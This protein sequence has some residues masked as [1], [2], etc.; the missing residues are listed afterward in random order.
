MNQPRILVVEDENIVALDIKMRLERFG[1]QVIAT[2]PSG[3]E[4]IEQALAAKPDLI[5][6]DIKLRGK[7][8]GIDAA[9]QIQAWSNIPIIFLTAFADE[10]T[11]QRAINAEPFGYILKPFDERELNLVIQVTLFRYQ[12]EE[13]LRLSEAAEREQRALAEALSDIAKTLNSTL[14]LQKIIY[15]ILNSANRVVASNRISLMLMFAPQTVYVAGSNNAEYGLFIAD[16][17]NHIY[18]YTQMPILAHM[19]KSRQPLVI[20]DTR[21]YDDWPAIPETAH[22]LA[23]MGAPIFAKD[24]LLGFINLSSRQAHAFAD[25]PLN[26]LQAFAD[27]AAIAL[28]NASL[29]QAT[30]T[31]AGLLEQR[32]AQ[33]TEEL[34][35]ERTRLQLILD[36]VGDPIYFTDPQFRIQYANAQ[37]EKTTGYSF[38][39]IL[40][41]TPA[42]WRGTTSAAVILEM[43][44]NTT[45]GKAWQGEVINRR[46]DGSLYPALLNVHPL[47]NTDGELTGFVCV[48]QN[49]TEIKELA[50]IKE[51]FVSRIGHELRTPLT[52][53][54]LYLDLLMKGSPEKRDYYATI[55]QHETTRLEKLIAGFLEMSLLQLE[56]SPFDLESVDLNQLITNI[57]APF[58]EHFSEK[59]LSLVMDL[60]PHLPRALTNP[61]LLARAVQPIIDNAVQYTPQQGKILVQTAS[62]THQNKTWCTLVVQDSGTGIVVEEES[63]IFNLFYRGEAA[64]DFT[65]PG[66]GLGLA[67]G[68]EIVERLNGRLTLHTIPGQGAAFTLWLPSVEP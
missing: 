63:K 7:L 24:K 40:N 39:E 9:R 56:T 25:K 35:Q 18:T 43:D 20:H 21:L 41:Q 55:I 33:R 8:D 38:S 64:R 60:C 47:H 51:Q 29:H 52:N 37:T 22:I 31:Y 3:E 17:P 62:Q 45:Q 23:Y 61:V 15:S 27:Q 50:H 54:K 36:E 30:Y 10:P 68:K 44:S 12:M 49:L 34:E 42:L 48:E 32:V 57:L 5:L 67:I 19:A 53:I 28:E 1:C 16:K 46:K 6:M 13:R 11:M 14:D 59:Q 66:A 26:S 4:A 58:Q 2:V 65:I